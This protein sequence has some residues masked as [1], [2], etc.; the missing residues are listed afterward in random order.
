MH[1]QWWKRVTSAL[2]NGVSHWPLV[3]AMTEGRVSEH[4]V[5]ECGQFWQVLY[6]LYHYSDCPMVGSGNSFWIV[7]WLWDIESVF[8]SV[9]AVRLR[10]FPK[11]N[12]ILFYYFIYL[13]FLPMLLELV[14]LRF[15]DNSK[16]QLQWSATLKRMGESLELSLCCPAEEQARASVGKW[17]LAKDKAMFLNQA[18]KKQEIYTRRDPG[19]LRFWQSYI[20][21]YCSD[22]PKPLDP[23]FSRSFLAKIRNLCNSNYWVGWIHPRARLSLD[24]KTQPW[25]LGASFILESFT[26]QPLTPGFWT[27]GSNF[28]VI[29]D[30]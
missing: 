17:A 24:N 9:M 1:T 19:V 16:K 6:Y 30:C 8:A 23:M 7:F 3:M 4:L 5:L 22:S 15:P 10:R 11:I 13:I 29:N 2:R 26:D 28:L 20:A 18:L 12:L 27:A 21:L 25:G 14:S